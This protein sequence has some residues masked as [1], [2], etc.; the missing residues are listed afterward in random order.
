MMKRFVH[1]V[2]L[3][4]FIGLWS[5]GHSQ[6]STNGYLVEC[7]S[8]DVSITISISNRTIYWNYRSSGAYQEFG[9]SLCA[10]SM[11]IS[12]DGGLMF[13]CVD[14]TDCIL[15]WDGYNMGKT[16]SGCYLP[17]RI[18][19]Y[20]FCEFVPDLDLCSMVDFLRWIK[21]DCYR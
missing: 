16:A 1:W 2:L 4:L 18:P 19:I 21:S 20:D 7:N 5:F 17:I 14:S 13:C 11:K 15:S 6:C 8:G 10:V 3:I 9:V 12:N